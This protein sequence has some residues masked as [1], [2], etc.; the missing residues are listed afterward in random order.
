MQKDSIHIFAKKKKWRD[1]FPFWISE[2][3]SG[4]PTFAFFICGLFNDAVSTTDYIA[5]NSWITNEQRI[6]KDEEGSGRGLILYTIPAFGWKDWRKSHEPSV[7][8]VRLW[9]EI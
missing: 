2:L 1:Q 6:G 5:S 3:P 7:K 8:I 9:A 4:H